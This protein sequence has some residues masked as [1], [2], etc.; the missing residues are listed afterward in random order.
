[1]LDGQTIVARVDDARQTTFALVEALDDEQ[2]MG[3]QPDIVNPLLWELGQLAWFQEYCV[4]RQ[5]AGHKPL[6]ANA[7]ELWNS[8]TVA[9]DTRWDLPLP[10]RADTLAHTHAAREAVDVLPAGDSVHGIRRLLGKVWEWTSSTF[11]PYPGFEPD[12]YEGS[13]EPWFGSRR[14][15]RGGSFATRGR[16]LRNTLRNYLPPDRRDV[17]AGFRTCAQ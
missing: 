3:P 5:L 12:V 9:H 1:M 4:P 6:R 17:W 16:L 2:L 14:V 8:S 15:L 7:D 10:S 11:E 13:S